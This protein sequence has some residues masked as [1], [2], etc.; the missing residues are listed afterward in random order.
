MIRPHERGYGPRMALLCASVALA[1]CASDFER[2]DR[3][4]TEHCVQMY[5]NAR[6]VAESTAVLVARV[7]PQGV[8][9]S[10]YPTCMQRM[11]AVSR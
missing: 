8:N 6:N 10:Y 4:Y 3:E 7:A 2:Q 1:G 9:V 11:H 5:A